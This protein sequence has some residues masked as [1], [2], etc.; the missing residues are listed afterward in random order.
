MPF[1]YGQRGNFNSGEVGRYRVS[2]LRDL[3]IQSAQQL[4]VGTF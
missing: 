4:G 1:I 3:C 2:G